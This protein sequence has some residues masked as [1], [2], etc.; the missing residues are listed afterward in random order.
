MQT[1]SGNPVSA[2]AGRA[3]LSTIREDDLAEA[4]RRRGAAL[5]DGFRSLAGRHELIGDVR[6]RGLAIGV[7]LV[8]DRGTREPASRETAKVVY[9]AFELGV[10]LFYVGLH[11]NVLELTPPLVLTDEEVAR[12]LEVLDQAFADVEAGRVSDE[13]VAAYAGW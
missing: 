4:A 7:D 9:R 2:S 3:V 12:A 6:G 8:L 11:S 5:V 10:V 1:T 13:V